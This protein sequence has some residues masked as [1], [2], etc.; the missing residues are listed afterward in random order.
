M[1]L[2]EKVEFVGSFLDTTPMKGSEEHI[3]APISGPFGT[4]AKL[5]QIIIPVLKELGI[6]SIVSLGMPGEKVTAKV[7]NCETHAWLS[8]Q[9]RQECMK[10]SKLIVFSGGHITCFET[11]KYAKPS[12]CIP[13]QPEQVGNAAKLQNLGCSI[14]VKN[15][16]ELKAAVQKIQEKKQFFRRNVTALNVFSNKFKGLDR[17]AEI[18][19]SVVK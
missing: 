2:R 1:H 6:K 8:S 18:I 5:T 9:E 3:F 4:R 16:R 17:A 12:I 10:N 19:E 11:I 13:T 14:A 7:G 15:K